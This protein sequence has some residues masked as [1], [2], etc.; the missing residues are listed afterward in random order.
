MLS[1]LMKYD[2]KSIKRLGIPAMIALA[3]LTLVSGVGSYFYVK[4]IGDAIERENDAGATFLII[5]A[6]FLLIAVV[7]VIYVAAIGVYVVISVDFYK[8]TATDE[9]YLTFTLP[10]KPSQ[11]ILSKFINGYL[12]QLAVSL[13][14]GAAI[15][16]LIFGIVGGIVEVTESEMTVGEV[17]SEMSIMISEAEIFGNL[18]SAILAGIQFLAA[19]AHT[20]LMYFMAIFFG[21]IIAKKHKVLAAIGCIMAAGALS[22]IIQS[23]GQSILYMTTLILTGPAAS[24]DS[25]IWGSNL[26]SVIQTVYYIGMSVL[27][28]FVTKYMMEKKLNLP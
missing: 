3:V 28:F 11:I 25:Y 4:I 9:A 20:L 19:T 1:K 13:L 21:S 15:F 26:V 6:M 5:G 22:G 17:F 18:V 8:F 7:S 10:V 12:W 14:T 2:F 27:Y 23:V 16:S 24:L